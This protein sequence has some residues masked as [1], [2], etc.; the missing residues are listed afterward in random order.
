M[1]EPI[2]GTVGRGKL[3]HDIE[4]FQGIKAGSADAVPVDE[5]GDTAPA[6]E[7]AS[8]AGGPRAAAAEH[9]DQDTPPPQDPAPPQDTPPAQNQDPAAAAAANEAAAAAQESQPPAEPE[10]DWVTEFPA[11]LTD[12]E[13]PKNRDRTR[14]QIFEALMQRGRDR[15]QIYCTVCHGYGGEGNG[16]VNQRAM[17]LAVSNVIEK[18]TATN[19]TWTQ[20]KS[21]HDPT[22]TVQPIGRIFDTIT[23]GRGTMGPYARQIPTED[24]WAIVLYVKALQATRANE[25]QPPTP[26]PAD[27]TQPQ[28]PPANAETP[29]NTET[30]TDENAGRPVP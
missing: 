12:P 5:T 25:P 16:L 14:E 11:A 22:V 30:G 15:F 9:T 3:Q 17:E 7:S 18:G 13:A 27:Q 2:P 4:F 26:A 21:L 20:V 8:D 28:P 24:R 23:N 19:A 10:P 29:S 1:R 6:G